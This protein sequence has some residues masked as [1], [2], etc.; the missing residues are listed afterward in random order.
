MRILSDRALGTALSFPGRPLSA[1]LRI[2]SRT[3]SD[4]RPPTHR[5]DGL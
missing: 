2:R 5:F 4:S 3:P 1:R